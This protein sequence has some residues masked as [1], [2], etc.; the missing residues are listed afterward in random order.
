[1]TSAGASESLMKIEAVEVAEIPT[2][3]STT[4]RGIE[5]NLNESGFPLKSK[6]SSSDL[7]KNIL[8][9]EVF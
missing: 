2:R 5:L 3:S 7:F 6:G 4:T 1:M 9:K 8:D